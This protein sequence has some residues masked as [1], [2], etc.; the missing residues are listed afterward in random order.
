MINLGDGLILRTIK[1]S[2]RDSLVK[3]ASHCFQKE[4]MGKGISIYVNQLVDYYPSFSL[5][6]NFIVV[7]TAKNDMVISWVNLNRKICVFES[8][9]IPYGSVDIVGTH[10]DYRNRGLVRQLFQALES[11]AM[12]YNLAFIVILGIPYFYKSFG[13]EYGV[14]FE[15]NIQISGQRMFNQLEKKISEFNIEKVV[16]EDSFSQYLETR[17]KRNKHLDLYQELSSKSFDFYNNPKLAESDE[18]RHFFLVKKGD[19]IIGN[20]YSMVRFGSFCIREL[21]L[22]NLRA[23][24]SIF[25]FAFSESKKYNL[26]ISILKPAQQEI[27]IEIENFVGSNFSADYAWFVKIPAFHL[28][29]EQITSILERRLYSSKY[30]NYTGSLSINYFKGGILLGLKNGKLSSIT[31]LINSEVQNSNVEFDLQIPPDSLMQLML[32]HKAIDSLKSESYDIS[33]REGSKF[34]IDI[35]FPKIRQSLTPAV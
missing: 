4:D 15:G 5:Q 31:R 8:V 18:A 12:E 14:R 11:R 10:R 28:F 16:D 6:D 25:R 17:A 13:Y 35:L 19:S 32:G 3:L 33:Y 27:L 24:N 30:K 22:E 29:L 7:D 34:L 21:F 20:F 9:K 2:D 26:P 1:E 23:V